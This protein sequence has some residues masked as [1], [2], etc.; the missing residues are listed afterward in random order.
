MGRFND[1]LGCPEV[2]PT[3]LARRIRGKF[4]APVAPSFD[5]E[6]EWPYVSAARSSQ[7]N[8]CTPPIGFEARESDS[9][10]AS[11]S[12][13]AWIPTDSVELQLRLCILAHTGSG[14]HRGVASTFTALSEYF[15]LTTMRSDILDFVKRCIHCL[16]TT[17]GSRVPRPLG[18]ALNADKPNVILHFDFLYV[19]KSSSGPIYI[20]VLRDDMS[21]Y[22]WLWPCEHADAASTVDA[23]TTFLC[24]FWCLYY[25]GFES[26]L[27]F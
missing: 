18:E 16:T 19:G 8:A 15:F 21:G 24:C 6:F 13:A 27:S 5:S 20:L 10:I 11:S 12:G 26:R 14:G 9:I 4:R 3:L 25:L 2:I 7:A 17:G 1:S 23:V 22:V